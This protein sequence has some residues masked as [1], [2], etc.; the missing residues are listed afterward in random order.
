MRTIPPDIEAYNVAEME[1]ERLRAAL[2]ASEAEIADL[3]EAF[4]EARQ[5]RDADR[6]AEEIVG[7]DDGTDPFVAAVR[8]TRMP[9]VI[10]NPRLPDNPIVFVNDAFCRLCGYP[11]EEIVGRN[12]RFLQ[13]VDTDPQAVATIRSAVRSQASITTDLLNYRKTGE[14]FWNRLLMAPVHDASGQ[15]TYFFASQVD[16]TLE[17]ER[18]EGLETHNA[19]LMAE[20]SDRLHAERENAARLQFAAEAGRL[21]IWESDLLTGEMM[22]SGITR[23]NY[24]RDRTQPFAQVE[25]EAAIH[26]DD[27]DMRS[28][29]LARSIAG[30]S[31]YD[32]ECRVICPDGSIRWVNKRAQVMRDSS[33][34]AIRL[35]GVSMDVTARRVAE[36]RRL[37]MEEVADRIRDVSDPADLAYAAAEILGRRLGVSRAGFGVADPVRET[38]TIERDWTEAGIAS[39]AGVLRYRD[40]G[41]FVGDLQRGDLI[42]IADVSTDARTKDT[43]E[44]LA[45]LNARAILSLPVAEHSGLVALLYLNHAA[46]RQWT[47]EEIEL[48]REVADRVQVAIQRRRAEAD[49]RALAAT[50]E[51][52]VEER[53]LAHAATEAQ[54]RQAQKMEAVG[55]LTGGLAHDFNNLLTGITG[56]LDLIK[57]R[58]SQGREGDVA[59]YVEIAMA[60]AKR[61]AALTHRLLAFS[62]R[63]TLEPKPTDV[64]RLV[65]DMVDL[66]RR[67]VGPASEVRFVS[68]PD[69]WTALVDPNQLENALLNL[70]INAR[71]AM[72]DGGR[73]TIETE[74][75]WIDAR[76]ASVRDIE[77]GPYLTLSVSDTGTGMPPDVVARAFDPFFTTK[78]LGQG[79]GLGLSMIYG[80]AKQSGGQVRIHSQPGEGTTVTMY[81]PRQDGITATSDAPPEDVAV[82]AHGEH[83]QTVLV[84]DDE[85]AIR[86]LVTDVLRDLG[87]TAL[88]AHDGPTGL[89]IVRSAVRIDLLV[90]DVGLPGGM[91]GRQVADAARVLRPDL[92]VLFI[93][94]YA[95]TAVMD[96]GHLDPGMTVLTKP[97]AM[98]ELA[99]RVRSLIVG[100]R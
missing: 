35:V 55:Q 94:G 78:P 48:V 88:Q 69:A 31:D 65:E 13:G 30:G 56:A 7:R 60:S 67:T 46:A 100:A 54:L 8:A 95:E 62:R 3:K 1:L 63:Q 98:D 14:P 12:C 93:T 64:A 23:E 79:T 68:G 61:A 70:C 74:N 33:G 29:A 43:A 2:A 25:L 50:L 83:G 82:M 9:M 18:L 72:P 76:S 47:D 66:I 20:V 4:H 40:Q 80:F 53:T 36:N 52:Q 92:R 21:G 44:A 6:V 81:L 22:S 85:P 19:A 49:L 73:L 45:S 59:R 37:V 75:R 41:F 87:Y 91:N 77:P 17:R 51:R 10:S 28:A 86:T 26:P 97:F 89:E 5:T 38:I 16:V 11:R 84:V 24:G 58:I 96:G 27:R 90:T 71:D 34:I 39:L 32:V 15:L 42:A 99:E 57:R